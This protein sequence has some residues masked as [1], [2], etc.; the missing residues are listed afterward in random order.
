MKPL[1]AIVGAFALIGLAGC[2]SAKEDAV[3]NAYENQAAA[4]ENQADVLENR[5]DN[6]V[7]AAQQAAENTADVL[8]NK[9][10]AVRD[11]GENA[12]ERV[13]NR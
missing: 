3:E 5:A 11:A 9:A 12:A 6:M 8:E 1:L 10:D 4:F 13:A 7:G 2:D